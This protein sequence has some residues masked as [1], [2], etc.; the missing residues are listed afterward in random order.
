MNESVCDVIRDMLRH[1]DN[2]IGLVLQSYAQRLL[3]AYE[4]ELVRDRQFVDGLKRSLCG[5]GVGR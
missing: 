2:A 1:T 5:E 4:A 3:T